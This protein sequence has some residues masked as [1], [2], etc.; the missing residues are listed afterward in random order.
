MRSVRLIEGR[1][2]TQVPDGSPAVVVVGSPLAPEGSDPSEA[3][4]RPV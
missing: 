1:L 2:V 3:S 4:S